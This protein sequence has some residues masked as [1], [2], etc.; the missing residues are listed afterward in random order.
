MPRKSL[1]SSLVLASLALTPIGALADPAIFSPWMGSYAPAAPDKAKDT[2][3][4]AIEKGTGSMAMLR[5]SVARNRLKSTN[6]PYQ[7]IRISAAGDELV[8][9]FDG[10]KYKA[11]TDGTPEKAKDPDGKPVTVSYA[12]EGDTLKSRYVGEDG[13]KM[14]DFER[15]PDGQ[16][17]IMHVTVI[18]EKIPQPIKYSVRYN[19]K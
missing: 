12:A 17:L 5:R 19:R 18:S 13:E 11:P 4:Q 16:G 10:R 1:L 2:I 3:E 9:D 15:T 8:T 6:K 7:T 14:M